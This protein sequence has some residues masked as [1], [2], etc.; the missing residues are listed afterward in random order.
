MNGLGN[1]ESKADIELDRILTALLFAGA[2]PLAV[3][4]LQHVLPE[5]PSAALD[6]SLRRLQERFAAQQ[7]PYA[8]GERG[9]AWQLQLL[10][11]YRHSF[12]L[13]L[14]S[15]N[16]VRLTRELLEVLS[17][18]AYRQP[19]SKS[20]LEDDLGIDAEASL[21]NLQRKQLISVIPADDSQ[22]TAS[23][24][25]TPRFLEVFGLDSVADLP[26]LQDSP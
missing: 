12:H 6:S 17:L 13:K 5:W 9:G 26:A 19:I 23:Y 3:D 18:V 16:G 1:A 7:R 4:Q 10:P 25:T 11:Q 14:R 20:D 22:R 8:L 24:A 15:E 2:Q 21:R